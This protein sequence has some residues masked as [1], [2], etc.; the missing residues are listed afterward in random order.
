MQCFRESPYFDLTLFSYDDK[1][2]SQLDRLKHSSDLPVKFYNRH[3]GGIAFRLQVGD[4][5]LFRSTPRANKLTSFVFHPYLPF[6]IT[7]L[8]A[9][10]PRVAPA[11]VMNFHFRDA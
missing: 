9:I 10:Q 2:V 1:I 5:T 4:E 6:A 3:H 7:V 8:H 11:S